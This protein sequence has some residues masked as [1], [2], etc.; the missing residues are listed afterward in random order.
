MA[1]TKAPDQTAADE[2]IAPKTPKAAYHDGPPEIQFAG[3]RWLRDMPQDLTAQE[4]A[5][6][7]A[8]PD[9]KH[10]DFTLED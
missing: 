9:F 1:K 4:W 10:F 7:Q 8:R 6:M 3:R 2:A 5:A